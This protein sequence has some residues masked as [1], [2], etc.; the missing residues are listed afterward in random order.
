MQPAA[1]AGE[2]H[3]Q[4]R[5]CPPRPCTGARRAR[6]DRLVARASGAKEETLR[7]RAS[8][9]VPH[10]QRRAEASEATREKLSATVVAEAGTE[11][12]ALQ[13]VWES[14][15]AFLLALGDDVQMKELPYHKI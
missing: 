12:K 11:A 1:G 10:R 7:L 5:P 2:E 8:T 4:R 14:L 15:K 13:D 6:R 3:K 9:T